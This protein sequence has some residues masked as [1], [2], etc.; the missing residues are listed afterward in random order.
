METQQTLINQEFIQTTQNLEEYFRSIK[1]KFDKFD[2][3]NL[4][5]VDRNYFVE[6]EKKEIF[7]RLDLYFEKIWQLIKDLDKEDYKSYQRYFQKIIAPLFEEPSVVNKQIYRKPLGYPGDYIVMNYIYDYSGNNKYL[8]KLSL[9]KLINNYT[10]NV[11]FSISNIIRKEFFKDRILEVVNRGEGMRILSVG[12]G[13]A[14]E[15]LE[16]IEEG[17]INKKLTFTCLDLEEKVLEYVKDRFEKLENSKKRLVTINYLH[18]NILELIKNKGLGDSLTN[19]DLVYASGL[20]DYLRERFAS[21][22][23]KELFKLLNKNCSLFI[24]NASA[25]N[26]SHRAYYEFLGDWL[27][28][29]RTKEEMLSWTKD[30]VNVSK[31]NF[32]NQSNST[33]YLFLNITKL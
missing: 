31:V 24:C 32:E 25:K 33:N 11:P 16:L 28:I 23:I 20:F 27:M 5:D 9:E 13:P 6:S 15:L 8:G 26:Y 17:K 19:Q 22:L 18:K 3:N 10:C 29:Y 7:K 4:S 30:L 21:K 2:T 1:A 14:R 12:S